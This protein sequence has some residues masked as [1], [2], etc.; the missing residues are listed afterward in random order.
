MHQHVLPHI[1]WTMNY[2]ETT[3]LC[4]KLLMIT[5]SLTPLGHSSRKPQAYNSKKTPNMYSSCT[6]TAWGRIQNNF[7]FP[8]N[9]LPYCREKFFQVSWSN[10]CSQLHT[11]HCSSVPLFRGKII[12][13]FSG[14][15]KG[16]LKNQVNWDHS[17]LDHTWNIKQP[18][19][20]SLLGKN[21]PAVLKKKTELK[22]AGN[23]KY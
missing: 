15:G 16:Q 19:L 22:T 13:R 8:T 3:F 11:E 2:W 7:N 4:L 18:V 20:H 23:T 9:Y 6:R 12:N 1:A 14:N 5:S 10:S 17:S 21:I